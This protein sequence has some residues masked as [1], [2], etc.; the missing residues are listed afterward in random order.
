MTDYKAC[1]SYYRLQG[2][3][4]LLG[5]TSNFTIAGIGPVKFSLK[6]KVILLRNVLHMPALYNPL[7]YALHTHN[8][9]PD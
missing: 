2:Y 7:L 5:D 6:G 1:V 3:H 4:T 9:M 8:S